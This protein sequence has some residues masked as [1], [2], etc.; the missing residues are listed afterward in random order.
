MEEIRESERGQIESNASRTLQLP[1]NHARNK[2]ESRKILDL[3]KRFI[4]VCV[5]VCVFARRD[6]ELLPTIGRINSWPITIG[7]YGDILGTNF[8]TFYLI[9]TLNVRM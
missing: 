1:V 8:L 9:I 6:D 3:I 4:S 7:Y 2:T 5:C